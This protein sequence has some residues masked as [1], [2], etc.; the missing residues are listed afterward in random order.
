[1]K[2]M[3]ARTAAAVL[4]GACCANSA[5]GQTYPSRPVRVIVP[6]PPGGVLDG[7]IRS[8]GQQVGETLGQPVLVENRAGGN[9]TIG[10]AT[11]AKAAPDGYT[12]CSTTPDTLSYNPHLFNNLPY[13]PDLDFAPVIQLVKIHGVIVTRAEMPFSSIRDMAAFDRAKPGALNWGTLGPGSGAQV[14]LSWINS[15]TGAAITPVPYK[16]VSQVIPALLGGEIQ[17]TYV[18]LGFVKAHIDAGT[19]K[20]LAITGPRRSLVLPDVPTLSEQGSD[21]GLLSWIGG[22]APGRP[23]KPIVDRLNAEFARALRVPTVQAVIRAQT[24]EPVG[25]T[26]AQFAEFLKLDR[27]NA[28]RIFKTLGI[29][30]SDAP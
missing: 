22:F 18:G 25:D 15:K 7:L 21:P 24:L 2:S 17:L 16:G 28:G 23:P 29:R 27:A 26:P 1:M 8:V 5:F 13:D 20:P 14:F 6:T 4:T 10:M 3:I 12:L 19:L 11:C 9:L 30:P